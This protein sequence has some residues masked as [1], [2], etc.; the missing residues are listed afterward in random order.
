MFPKSWLIY[1][2]ISF[3][4]SFCLTYLYK[5]WG[6]R[7]SVLDI[8]N[9]RSSHVTPVPRGGGIVFVLSFYAGILYLYYTGQFEKYLFLALIPGLGLALVGFVDDLKNLGPIFRFS[10]QLICSAIAL[11]FLGGFP[12]VFGSN[13]TLIGSIVALFGIVW[14]INLFNFLDGSDGYAS[15]EAISISLGFWCFTKTNILLLL[16]FSVGGFLYWNWPKAKIFMGDSGSTALGFILIVFGIHFHNNGTLSFF[17][18]IL[19]TALFWSDATVTLFRRILNREKLSMAHKNHFY[20][21]AMLGGVSHLKV[22]ISGLGMNLILFLICF[23]IW[24]DV[25]SYFLGLLIAIL[26]LWFVMNHVDRK[27]PFVK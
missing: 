2:F 21:R 26:I 27:F 6:I 22:L 19:I 10:A 9:E 5:E 12:I 20:Q 7:R 11:Y 13:P 15:M 18:W 24:K 16:A 1:Y 25:I 23:S 17:F 4:F 3:F 14:F 8:P